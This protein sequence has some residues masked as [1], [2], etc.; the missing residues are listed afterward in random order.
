MS[1]ARHDAATITTGADYPFAAKTA[2]PIARQP[3][4]TSHPVLSMSEAI[5]HGQ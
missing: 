4:R 3:R 1:L 2:E 5:D